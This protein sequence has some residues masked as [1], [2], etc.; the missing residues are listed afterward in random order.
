MA[1]T[2]MT[3]PLSVPP[4]PPPP[5]PGTGPGPL[6][7]PYGVD[8]S[9]SVDILVCAVLTSFIGCIFVGLRFYTRRN[10]LNVLGLEDWLMLAVQVFSVAMS[11]GF[12]H[13]TRCHSATT[14]RC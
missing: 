1:D 5:P 14:C 12:I 2:N 10:I 7:V 4:L 3:A 13:P 6:G 11:V 8:R 9:Y